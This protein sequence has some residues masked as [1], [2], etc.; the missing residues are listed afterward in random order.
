[1]THV[2]ASSWE[3]ERKHLKGLMSRWRKKTGNWHFWLGNIT[4]SRIATGQ[5][6]LHMENTKA[7]PR[8]NKCHVLR[9]SVLGDRSINHQ[10]M[11][12]TLALIAGKVKGFA[13]LLSN[14][15]LSSQ[16]GKAG[17]ALGPETDNIYTCSTQTKTHSKVLQTL[18]FRLFPSTLDSLKKSPS[19][20]QVRGCDGETFSFG[21]VLKVDL[22]VQSSWNGLMA[23]PRAILTLKKRV[24]RKAI[25][26][27]SNNGP[28]DDHNWSQRPISYDITYMWNLEKAMASHSSTLAWKIA[29]MEEP[30]GLQ[31]MGS[32]RVGRDW[33]TSLSLFTF[34]HWRRKWQPTP[35]F[36]PGESQGQGSLV[37]CRLWGCTE[38]DMTEAT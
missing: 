10:W 2:I 9:R 31:S 36:L 35:V 30:G 5:T 12:F 13:Y 26:K 28:R 32:L 8:V 38:L 7:L 19:Q 23:L 33:A 17:P 20:L 1:M 22:P 15:S 16:Q 24:Y 18:S 11:F 6:F 29:W 34:M 37:G 25:Y 4:I 3:A 21:F 27:Q 14:R